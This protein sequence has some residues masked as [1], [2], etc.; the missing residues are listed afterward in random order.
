MNKKKRLTQQAEDVIRFDL[1]EVSTR[2][3]RE[4]EDDIHV[5]MEREIMTDN[6]LTD[7]EKKLKLDNIK[8][9]LLVSRV[10]GIIDKTKKFESAKFGH[11][12]DKNFAIFKNLDTYIETKD[13]WK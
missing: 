9:L 13:F 4:V 8:N 5:K 2:K 7:E 10:N 11:L 3:R 12:M 1:G 6:S